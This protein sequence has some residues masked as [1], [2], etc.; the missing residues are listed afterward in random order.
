MLKWYK[1]NMYNNNTPIIFKQRLVYI[2]MQKNDN[3]WESQM[4]V[5]KRDGSLQ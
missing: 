2:T 4:H 1:Y 3:M 5:K